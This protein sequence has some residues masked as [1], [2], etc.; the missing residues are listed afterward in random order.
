V[1]LEAL[2]Q[3]PAQAAALA[4]EIRRAVV[5]QCLT[6]LAACAVGREAPPPPAR[7]PDRVLGIEEAAARLGMTRDFLYRNWAALRLGY[8]DADGHVKFPLSKVERYIRTR[9]GTHA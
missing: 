6:I 7:E 9:I 3:D 2:A 8:K 5:L 1:S 4:P